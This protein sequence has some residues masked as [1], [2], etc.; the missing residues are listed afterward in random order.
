MRVR[1]MF[2]SL[3]T[4]V[5]CAR[6][7]YR[8]NNRL[9]LET[10]KRDALFSLRNSRFNFAL[11]PCN[12]SLHRQRWRIQFSKQPQISVNSSKRHFP[13]GLISERVNPPLLSSA[14]IIALVIVD[15]IVARFSRIR[16]NNDR[17]QDA[18]TST[19][20]MQVSNADT[21]PPLWT[22]NRACGRLI[23][24]TVIICGDVQFVECKF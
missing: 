1:W 14:P 6:N 4:N 3:I 7:G 23:E 19:R 8:Y 17:D 20:W 13:I 21:E 10:R 15:P 11:V 9:I 12:F 24:A 16:N 22:R 5:R 2:S 18:C